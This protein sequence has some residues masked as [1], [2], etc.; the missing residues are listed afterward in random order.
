MLRA[1]KLFATSLMG[2]HGLTPR[3]DR[4]EAIYPILQRYG[5]QYIVLEDMP[6]KSTALDWL[7]DELKGPHFAERLR[8]PV[9]SSDRRLRGVSLAVYEYLDATPPDPNATLELDL[10]LVGRRI[11]VPLKDLTGG[12]GVRGRVVDL[13]PDRQP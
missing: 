4:P 9:N 1:D 10:P 11:T 5:T 6:S 12:A 13:P 3:I 8:L 2:W 7:R